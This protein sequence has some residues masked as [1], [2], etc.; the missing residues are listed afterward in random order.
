MSEQVIVYARRRFQRDY[1]RLV[2]CKAGLIVSTCTD[3]CGNVFLVS[4]KDLKRLVKE[5]EENE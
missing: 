5:V 4:K 1:I 2:P 3:N